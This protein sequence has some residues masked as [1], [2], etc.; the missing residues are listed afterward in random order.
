MLHELAPLLAEEGIDVDNLDDY[1]LGQL[2]QLLN[3]AVERRNLELLSPV[4]AVRILAVNT[5]KAVVEAVVAGDSRRA[6]QLLEQIQPESPDNSVAT[7]ASC[8]GI[9]LG[10][11]LYGSALAATITATA[12]ATKMPPKNIADTLIR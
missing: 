6:G 5:L 2:Q 8:I 12:A 10:R 7:V 1:G 11:V 4:G 9:A 3:R